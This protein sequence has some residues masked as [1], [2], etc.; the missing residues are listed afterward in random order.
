MSSKSGAGFAEEG[1]GGMVTFYYAYISY[2]SQM[3]NREAHKYIEKKSRYIDGV[4][5]ITKINK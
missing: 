4:L 5:Y 1:G 2:P 3:L